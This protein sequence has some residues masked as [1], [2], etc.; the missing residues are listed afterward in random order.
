MKYASNNFPY[1]KDRTH[2]RKAN[3]KVRPF[4]GFWGNRGTWDS[5]SGVQGNRGPNIQGTEEH[6]G[7]HR[8]QSDL[9][10]GNKGIGTPCEGPKSRS[11]NFAL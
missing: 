6:F 7:E 11:I 10:Q 9:F 2:A 4:Q 3:T 5:I 8:Q 1:A